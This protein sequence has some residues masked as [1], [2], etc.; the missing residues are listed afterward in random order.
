ML[1]KKLLSLLFSCIVL[2]LS[3]TI[4]ESAQHTRSRQGQTSISGVS[5]HNGHVRVRGYPRKNGTY[6]APHHRSQPNHTE[7]DNWS[8]NG[9]M[10]SDTGKK[11]HKTPRH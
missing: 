11:G 3:L 10:N 4:P 9:N 2:V 5:N 1:V 7:R 6:V 8:A